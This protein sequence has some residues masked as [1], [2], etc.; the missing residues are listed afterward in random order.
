[1]MNKLY[2]R[3]LSVISVASVACLLMLCN[4]FSCLAATSKTPSI[5]LSDAWGKAGDTV[6]VTITMSNNP[7]F[8]SA[9]LYVVY[10]E[11][12]LTLKSVKDGGLLSGVTHSDS[13][14]SPYGLCWL[15]DLSTENFTVNG[16]L[17]T[18][19]FEISSSAP[20]GTTTI[21]LEQDIIDCNVES[22]VFAT[23]SGTVEIGSSTQQSNGKASKSASEISDA[24]NQS[25]AN[26]SDKDSN[27]NKSSQANAQRSDEDTSAPAADGNGSTASAT[28]ASGYT[29][30]SS[31]SPDSSTDK[32]GGDSKTAIIIAAAV[33]LAAALSAVF[34]C[35]KSKAK[36]KNK[37][38]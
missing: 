2:K 1:M 3:T 6:D 30:A 22:V 19:S 10:D 11:A 16:T 33:L 20:Q 38:K 34:V 31:S 7:G 8:A 29:L 36:I 37:S 13:Y 4:V 15:N 24:P 35:K 28:D 5:A 27:I 9:N 23:E 12:V 25:S 14:T 18:L 32:N 17:A 21:S 26:D